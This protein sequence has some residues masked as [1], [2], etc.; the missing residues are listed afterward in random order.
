MLRATG[1]R[2]S[3]G[4]RFE[5]RAFAFGWHHG[6]G[7]EMKVTRLL[8]LTVLI[9]GSHEFPAA[10]GTPSDDSQADSDK[11]VILN[12]TPSAAADEPT[13]P[14]VLYWD[15]KK[16]S[17]TPTPIPGARI[18]VLSLAER[19]MLR[20]SDAGLRQFGKAESGNGTTVDLAGR[21][22]SVFVSLV[23]LSGR[24]RVICL[25]AEPGVQA[26]AAERKGGSRAQ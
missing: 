5:V 16:E 4:T 20:R 6:R 9:A 8:I 14:L 25:D 23:D 2:A 10:A 13:G 11:G 17:L 26:R 21:Y 12:T 22:Q 19:R 7:S 18:I 3:R 1:K 24:L 15:E